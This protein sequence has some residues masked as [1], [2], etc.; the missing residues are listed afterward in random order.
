MGRDRGKLIMLLRGFNT[1][2]RKQLKPDE[3]IIPD[4]TGIISLNDHYVASRPYELL[5]S[6]YHAEVQVMVEL[7]SCF[8]GN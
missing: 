1:V 8:R 3:G 2:Q 7:S 5:T 6:L 4:N